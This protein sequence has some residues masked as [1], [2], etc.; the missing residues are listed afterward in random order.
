MRDVARSTIAGTFAVC[1]A[2]QAAGDEQVD[3][4]ACK[5]PQSRDGS[6]IC[7]YYFFACRQP[8]CTVRSLVLQQMTKVFSS[9]QS[10]KPTTPGRMHC[11]LEID[12][13]RISFRRNEPVRFLR[14]VVVRYAAPMQLAQKLRGGLEIRRI[15]R[16]R[17]LH[18]LSFEP[19]SAKGVAAVTYQPGYALYVLEY[20]ERTRLP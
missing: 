19:A 4:L 13:R 9:Q 18:R 2:E 10:K 16:P 14:Q 8:R 1:P 5:H 11:K 20:P 3:R 15:V 7:E 17:D 12:K 6:G